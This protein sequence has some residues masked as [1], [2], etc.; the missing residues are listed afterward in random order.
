M[1]EHSTRQILKRCGERTSPRCHRISTN[2]SRAVCPLEARWLRSPPSASDTARF[3]T[4]CAARV[5]KFQKKITLSER[6]APAILRN[7][8]WPCFPR[9]ARGKGFSCRRGLDFFADGFAFLAL[10]AHEFVVELEPEPEAGGG[11][12]IAAKTEII[13]RCASTAGLFHVREVRGGDACNT[14][15]FRLG[16]APFIDGLAKGFREEIHQ[17]YEL[18]VLFHTVLVV[19][20]DFHFG[21]TSVLP[22]ENQTPLLIDSDAPKS[23][24]IA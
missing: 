5:A 8:P 14:R 4:A 11:A 6:T 9:K 7:P 1:T 17:G 12:E 21:C 13:L 19:V 3:T 18:I 15:N 22:T 16:N 10:G 2:A 20:G 24:E 23:F